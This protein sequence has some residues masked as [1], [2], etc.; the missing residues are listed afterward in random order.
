[1]TPLP[2]SL[3]RFFPSREPSF[4]SLFLFLLLRSPQPILSLSRVDPLLGGEDASDMRLPS[5]FQDMYTVRLMCADVR[6]AD[7]FISP[8]IARRRDGTDIFCARRRT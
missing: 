5:A 6:R 3:A 8:M 4:R 7:K 2:R 1:M